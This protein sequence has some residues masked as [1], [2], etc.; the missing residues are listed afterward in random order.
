[1]MEEIVYDAQKAMLDYLR[2]LIKHETMLREIK[3]TT[4]LEGFRFS[5]YH[6]LCFGLR[7][8][9][10]RNNQYPK[11][12][13]SDTV[14]ATLAASL[15]HWKDWSGCPMY[16]VEGNPA[17][18]T[19]CK[20]LWANDKRWALVHFLE[21]WLSNVLGDFDGKKGRASSLHHY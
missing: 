15:P 19:N 21:E 11:S 20:H 5:P 1:M 10:H 4:T 7:L 16:P 6:G 3:E 12:T 17:H 8:A 9:A 18:F 13:L 14:L 2:L